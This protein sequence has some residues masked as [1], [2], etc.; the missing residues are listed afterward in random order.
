GVLSIE[1]EECLRRLM[2]QK[3]DREDFQAFMRLQA[4][5]MAGE[6]RQESRGE[7]LSVCVR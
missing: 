7:G 4:A 5:A 6:I 3:Y 1:A 2:M